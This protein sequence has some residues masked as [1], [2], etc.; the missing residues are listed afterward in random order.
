LRS[1]DLPWKGPAIGEKIDLTRLKAVDRSGIAGLLS[2][3]PVMLASIN[4]ACGMCSIAR[5]EMLFVREHVVPAGVQYYA[6]CFSPIDSTRNFYEYANS[7]GIAAPVFEWQGEV[8][9]PRSILD[10]TVPSHLLIAQDGAVLQ[11][12]P[13][14]SGEKEVRQR[15]GPQIVDDT[16]IIS[17]IFRLGASSSSKDTKPPARPE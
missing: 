11:V 17:E 12:W 8:A 6:V 9:P 2:K 10:M 5:D 13:G 14:P 15:M 16:L 3:Q 7:I 1:R 4:P